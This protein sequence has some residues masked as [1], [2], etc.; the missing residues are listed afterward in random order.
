MGWLHSDETWCFW[1][2]FASPFFNPSRACVRSLSRVLQVADQRP[3]KLPVTFALMT[4]L[5]RE[6]NRCCDEMAPEWDPEDDEVGRRPA[7][8]EHTRRSTLKT[9]APKMMC[10][11][12]RGE[13]DSY[14]RGVSSCSG[15]ASAASRGE[16][17]NAVE[18]TA[19]CSCFLLFFSGVRGLT[20]G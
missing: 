8:L 15:R 3:T 7:W 12:A 6:H 13:V 19:K 5:L 18:V 16:P 11:S 20:R 10:T 9:R 4:L 17:G 2:F 1:F 14:R